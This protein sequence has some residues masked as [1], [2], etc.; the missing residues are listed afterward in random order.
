MADLV[1]RLAEI[2][3]RVPA[4]RPLVHYMPNLV[5]AGDVANALLAAGAAPVM[6]IAVEE[7]ADIRADALAL[8]LGTPTAERLVALEAAARAAGER[9]A[10]IVLDPVGAGATPF[11]L[12]AARRL[13]AAAPVRCLRLNAGEAAALLDRPGAGR[14]VD[15]AGAPADPAELATA[16]ARRYGCVAAVTG[17]TDAVADGER[18]ILIEAGHPLLARVTGTG[19]MATGLVAACAAVEPDPLLASAAGLLYFGVAG[20]RAARQAAGPG[21]L[22]IGLCDALAACDAAALREEGRARWG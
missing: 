1:A 14:G 13:L 7:V 5:T 15:A 9:G 8:N 3:L 2:A 18:V 4:R 21:S 10:P 6:A 12:A 17:P 16:L 22:R 20:A 19:C 11:R